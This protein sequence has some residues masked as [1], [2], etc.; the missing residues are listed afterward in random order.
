MMHGDPEKDIELSIKQNEGLIHVHF[1][2]RHIPTV[3]SSAVLLGLILAIGLSSFLY[4]REASEP[5]E[6]MVENGKIEKIAFTYGSWPALANAEFFEKV[7]KDFISQKAN[8][9]EADLSAMVIR[10]YEDGEPIKEAPIQTKGREGSWW[11]TPAGLYQVLSKEESHFSSFGR[12]YMPWSIQFQGNFF[13]HG[14]TYYPD[15]TPTSATY[16][17]G[18]I[19][20]SNE[21]A[22]EIYKLAKKGTPVLVF[23]KAFNGGSGKTASHYRQKPTLTDETSYIAADLEN[24]F[25]FAQNKPEEIR[26]IASITK[27]M[28]ALISVEYINVEKEVTIDSLSALATT[29]IPRLKEGEKATVL[30]LLSLALMESSNQ[31]ALAVT[32][33]LGKSQF[34]KLMNEKAKAI[35]MENSSFAD[36]SGVLSADTSSAADLFLLAKYL[37]YNRSFVLHMSMGKENRSAYGVSKYRNVANLNDIPGISGLIGAKIGLSSSAKDSMFAVFKIKISGETRPVAIIVLG[38]DDAKRDVKT[39]LDYIGDN[40]SLSKTITSAAPLLP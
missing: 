23:E 39:L 17:G 24:N 28:A 19:R 14:P 12:V 3:V 20:L 13:I 36:T 25:V 22:E 32:A 35:G 18:C 21:D 4:F 7:K 27:L 38:S 33:P 10:Y 16:S 31:A 5:S 37:N 1:L 40:F 8:F 26:S 2:R 30:D 6:V 15:D 34:V 9:I 11:E 29:S